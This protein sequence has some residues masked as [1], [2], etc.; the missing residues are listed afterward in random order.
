MKVY[1]YTV[2]TGLVETNKTIISH[3]ADRGLQIFSNILPMP[4]SALDDPELKK[5]AEKG[6][7]LITKMDFLMVE[8]SQFSDDARFLI[9]DAI[10][11][12]KPVL[13]LYGKGR[14]LDESLKTFRED[15]KGIRRLYFR[16]YTEGRLNEIFDEFIRDVLFMLDKPS[17]KF[18]LR[19]TPSMDRY[20]GWKVQHTSM[21]KA[22]FLRKMFFEHVIFKD[23]GY[24]RMV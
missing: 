20:L 7:T 18:T 8:G 3:L 2:N 1:F 21:S 11:K 17:I 24:Q 13:V 12:Q 14:K 10:N 16:N 23:E 15:G 5:S 9:A 22:D 6:E 4:S 19:L